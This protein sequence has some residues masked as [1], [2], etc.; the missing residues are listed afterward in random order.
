MQPISTCPQVVR[1]PPGDGVQGVVWR[2]VTWTVRRFRSV[3]QVRAG[4]RRPAHLPLAARA[5]VPGPGAVRQGREICDTTPC[6]VRT[7]G[8]GQPAWGDGRRGRAAWGRDAPGPGA[9]GGREKSGHNPMQRETG[10]ERRRRGRRPARSGAWDRTPPV[11]APV[12]AAKNSATTPCNV[13]TVRAGGGAAGRPARRRAGDPS[14][15]PSAG[16]GREKCGNNPMQ[17]E[18]GARGR[19]SAGRRP[20]GRDRG[21]AAGPGAGGGLRQMRPQPHAT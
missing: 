17:R 6:N 9:G 20:P 19:G 18:D 5:T 13:R 15:R 2:R 11:R 16:G 12:A 8:A 14:P 3:I 4:D 1:A 10:R 7:V 21:G